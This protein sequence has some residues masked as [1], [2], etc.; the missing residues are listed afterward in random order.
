MRRSPSLPL[1]SIGDS[2]RPTHRPTISPPPRVLPTA[3]YPGTR[4]NRGCRASQS[5]IAGVCAWRDYR[6]P[7][8]PPARVGTALSIAARNFLNST[9]RCWRCSSEITVPSATLDGGG[10]LVRGS[11]PAGQ[12]DL[13]PQRQRLLFLRPPR[14]LPGAEL[15]A[16]VR[17][18]ASVRDGVR[19]RRGQA[20]AHSREISSPC[21]RGMAAPAAGP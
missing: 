21:V 20:T 14:R 10:L 16:R 17:R 9:A 11:L 7:D 4:W 19:A 1:R 15:A 5:R 18:G 6:R 8:A 12:H 13:G 2:S 3:W